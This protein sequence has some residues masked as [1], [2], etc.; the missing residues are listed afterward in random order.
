MI[1]LKTNHVMS[2][3]ILSIDSAL[4]SPADQSFLNDCP[5]TQHCSEI[6]SQ[7]ASDEWLQ[8]FEDIRRFCEGLEFSLNYEPELTLEAM[9]KEVDTQYQS[10]SDDIIDYLESSA[11]LSPE[12]IE[13][14]S[15]PQYEEHE[16]L[17]SAAISLLEE[18]LVANADGNSPSEQCYDELTIP[19]SSDSEISIVSD[20]PAVTPAPESR[21]KRQIKRKAQELES[22][23]KPKA[24]RSKPSVEV[25]RER[26]RSQNKC[27]ANRYRQKKRAEMDG[28]D[29]EHQHFADLNGQLRAQLQKLQMEFKVVYPLAKA[30]FA[31]DPNRSLQL[32]MLDIRVLN[33][34]LLD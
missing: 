10:K 18:I 22:V 13:P 27:A 34:E 26:K 9:T 8:D 21:P 19:F 30:A 15:P 7:L 12:S 2:T 17:E 24:K 14:L 5:Q 20:S 32:Q 31:S 11:L 6:T 33:E 28:M 29:K 23:P 1:A 4:L 3:E 16:T 25:K